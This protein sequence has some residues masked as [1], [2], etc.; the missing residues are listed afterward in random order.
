MVKQFQ[1]KSALHKMMDYL[2]QRNHSEHEL[3]KKLLR[4]EYTREEI[5]EAME[6]ARGSTWMPAPEVL[7]Q[8]VAD[9]LHRKKKSHLYIMQYLKQK[10]LP[11]VA[12]NREI[13]L[14]KA[15]S[16]ARKQFSDLSNLSQIDK[17]QVARY[18]QGRGF[19]FETINQ[20]IKGKS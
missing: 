7:S 2:A 1:R 14:D 18:L 13:E 10:K 3:E 6:K 12:K 20:V 4:A 9:S 8:K 15:L 11:L 17:K 16:L 5:A 19:D